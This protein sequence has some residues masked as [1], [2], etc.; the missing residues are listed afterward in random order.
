MHIQCWLA[1]MAFLTIEILV[2]PVSLTK[3][4]GPYVE[5]FLIGPSPWSRSKKRKGNQS[6]NKD[7]TKKSKDC[8]L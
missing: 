5:P 6:I 2:P 8:A 7:L 4:G 3:G 1:P